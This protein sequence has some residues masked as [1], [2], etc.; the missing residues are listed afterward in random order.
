MFR[1]SGSVVAWF[2]AGKAPDPRSPE[3]AAR[4]RSQRFRT[5]ED[6][7]SEEQSVGWVTPA[8]P[9]GGS[10]EPE[11]MDL[12]CATWL[13]MRLDKKSLPAAWLGIHRS[14]AE[15]SAGR[16][17]TARE[18]KDLKQDLCEKLLPRVLPT[19]S[20]VDALYVP[21]RGL[22]LLFSS[23]ARV[24]EEFNKLFFRTFAQ[25]LVQAG[26]GTLATRVGLPREPLAYLEQVAPVP[27]PGPATRAPAARAPE[28]RPAVLRAVGAGGNEDGRNGGDE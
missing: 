16:R 10:F 1:R 4:L 27:W 25:S 7:A 2:V 26:P 23:S 11:D 19:V 18:R 13:R 6:A 14:T 8:D 9:T 28:G 3:F 17:L 24:R 12:D 5:I 22:V 20:L 21:D 15:R